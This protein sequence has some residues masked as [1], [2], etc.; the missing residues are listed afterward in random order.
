MSF[1][2]Y[3]FK[4]L[5]NFLPIILL[6]IFKFLH[7]VADLTIAEFSVKEIPFVLAQ[8]QS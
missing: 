2:L 8:M 4:E 3:H 1:I 5:Q 6:G 7:A